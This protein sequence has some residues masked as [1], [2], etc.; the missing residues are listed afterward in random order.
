M[1]NPSIKLGDGNWSAK[2]SK[3]LGFR[4]IV[5]KV[6]PIEFDVSRAS[7]ATRV[8]RDGLIES[9]ANN[10]A[11]VDFADDVNG[12]LLLE[13][14][15]T[16]LVTYSELFLS[17]WW[18][19]DNGVTITDNN[20]TSPKGDLTGSLI[21]YDVNSV[22]IY[23]A[24]LNLTGEYTFSIYLKASGSNI[25]KTVQ[26]DVNGT[27]YNVTLT[28]KWIRSTF[29]T[30]NL[31]LLQITNRG[32]ST[33]STGEYYAFGAQLE[34]SSVATS[35][36]PTSGTIVTRLADAVS[37]AGDVNTINS[38]ENVL[39]SELI[40]SDSYLSSLSGIS[41]SDG[42]N[43]N[44][45]LLYADS[46]V[47]SLKFFVTIGGVN[48]VNT[49]KAGV[50]LGSLNKIAIRFELNNYAVF[51][52]GVKIISDLSVNA[53]PINTFNDFSF[54]RGN[55]SNNFYGKVKDLRI[56][57]TALTDSELTQLTTI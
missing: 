10:I 36:I 47:N 55:G 45:I 39:Y 8:N 49:L 3:L 12:S 15:G 31:N 26:V 44:E 35:Y 33:I 38:E 23:K 14:Q 6:A 30:T 57:N 17:G 29:Q 24:A 7:T 41:I 32:A 46:S 50:I 22:A 43:S 18:S 37:G 53:P 56:Y 34:Q 42:T 11:R 40:F 5:N 48:Q 21:S 27:L 2:D 20:E 28:S 9:V 51:L 16:N 52:N 19:K 1:E 25:G 4:P 13:P 54:S